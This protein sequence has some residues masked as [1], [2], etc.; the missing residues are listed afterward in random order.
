MVVK[1]QSSPFGGQTRTLVAL[2]LLESSY[3]RELSRILSVP[4][5]AVS[6]ALAGL[7]RDALVAGRAVGRT[8]IFT[9]S[10]TYF[11]RQE[12]SAYLSRLSDADADLRER[13]AQLRRRHVDLKAVREWSRAEGSLDGYDEFRREL[14]RHE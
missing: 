10:P 9:L 5:S 7:E 2:R 12:L 11:A 13:T 14:R 6:R 4:V 1:S 8:R 3:P